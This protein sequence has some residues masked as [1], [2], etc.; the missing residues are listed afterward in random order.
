[1]A[2]GP[3]IVLDAN[4]LIRAV[5][6][7]RVKEIITEH[8]EHAEFFAPELA[9]AEAERHLPEILAKYS[10]ADQIDEA[11]AYLGGLQAVVL[12]VPEEVYESVRAA[13]LSRIESRDPDDWP[14]LAAALVIECPI[15]TEDR[16]FFGTGV[17]TWT[18][19]RVELYLSANGRD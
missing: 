14:V 16:D 5:L 9:Y 19:D 10:R 6:G 11:L 1:V 17:P 15:W 2:A 3:R 4:I 7:R 13:A 18:T 8:A 12:P